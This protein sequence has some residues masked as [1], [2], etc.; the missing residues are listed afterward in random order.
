MWGNTIVDRLTQK[1]KIDGIRKLNEDALAGE[2]SQSIEKSN[3]GETTPAQTVS[4][5]MKEKYR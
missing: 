5:N 3:R 1:T 4:K 2:L